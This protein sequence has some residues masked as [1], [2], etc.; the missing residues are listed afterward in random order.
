MQRKL[1]L[2]GCILFATSLMFPQL[3]SRQIIEKGTGYYPVNYVDLMLNPERYNDKKVLVFGY[4]QLQSEDYALYFIRDY[5]EYQ[6]RDAMWLIFDK[7]LKISDTPNSSVD[8]KRIMKEINSSYV[9]LKGKFSSKRT[10]HLEEYF[11]ILFVDE[12]VVMNRIHTN[13]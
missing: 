1:I 9:A 10:G 11:G 13:K 5:A 4:L 6:V 2:L 12:I 7:E 8:I 3:D